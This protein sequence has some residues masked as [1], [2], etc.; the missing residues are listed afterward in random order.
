MKKEIIYEE[1]YPHEHC[2]CYKIDLP[3]PKYHQETMVLCKVSE[4]YEQARAI[5]IGVITKH[6]LDKTVHKTDLAASQKARNGGWPKG[7]NK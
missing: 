3:W 4:G 5:A 2:D 1:Y 7:E 6:L